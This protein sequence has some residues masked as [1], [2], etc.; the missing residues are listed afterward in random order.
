MDRISS[1]AHTTGHL[2]FPG[3]LRFLDTVG[4]CCAFFYSFLRCC[5]IFALYAF[6]HK[7]VPFS[8]CHFALLLLHFAVLHVCA[9]CCCALHFMLCFL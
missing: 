4:V 8:F 2:T 9:A 7:T 6:A 1:P 3:S 5:A